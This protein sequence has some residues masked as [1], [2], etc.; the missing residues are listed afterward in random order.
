MSRRTI[1]DLL[2]NEI[3][4]VVEQRNRAQKQT[5]NFREKSRRLTYRLEAAN[6]NLMPTAKALVVAEQKIKDQAKQIERQEAIIRLH[7][8][9][10]GQSVQWV[11]PG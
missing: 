7:N 8:M 1:A 4:K 3:A 6:A 9:P 11:K 2:R 5:R 10:P